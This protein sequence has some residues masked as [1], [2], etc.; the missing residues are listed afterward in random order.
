MLFKVLKLKIKI[1]LL[2]YL[3]ELE[4]KNRVLE[5]E[6]KK[7]NE[8]LLDKMRLLDDFNNK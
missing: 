7:I 3:R 1:I 4:M 8:M 5:I 6:N 2:S